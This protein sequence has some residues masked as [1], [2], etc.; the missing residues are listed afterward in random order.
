MRRL[1]WLLLLAFV[2]AIPWEDSL[3]LGI[4]IGNIAR[5]LGLAVLVSAIPAVLQRRSIRIPGPVQW[6]TLILLLWFCLTLFWS[7]DIDATIL[8]LRG[9]FQEFMIVWLLW[10]F[11]E[12]E[13]D[14]LVVFRAWLAGSWILAALTALNFATASSAFTAQVRFA[15]LGQ[16]PND[17]AR[18]LDL[19][20][21]IAA[22]LLMTEKSWLGRLHAIGYFP[23]SLAAVLLTAS[24][25]G[26]IVAVIALAGSSLLLVRRYPRGLLAGSIAIFGLL[27]SLYFAVPR[28]TIARLG[29]IVAQLNGG[30][31]NQRANIWQAGWVAFGD[32][33][34]IGHGA[35]TFVEAAGLSPID[36]AHNTA[37]SVAVEGGLLG[38]TLAVAIPFTALL[39]A[40][41]TSQPLRGTLFTA[42]SVWLCLSMVGTTG[43]S[44]KTWLLF[45]IMAFAG[46]L[47][48]HPHGTTPLPAASPTRCDLHH[49]SP[50][51]AI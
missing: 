30:N 11:T 9:Y 4:G 27:A 42:F 46:H 39:L 23:L 32:A 18:Y 16:D 41:R 8:K 22:F 45:G 3:D 47:A 40:A 1:T 48:V 26:V 25:A 7:I 15:A 10:E 34:L 17:V 2:F 43:E 29:T 5:L 36:T 31:L 19:A 51:S 33:P 13:S 6:L 37:L 24:R 35:G 20:L 49:P 50:N 21:P 12:R 44:R 14:L 38:L 28:G